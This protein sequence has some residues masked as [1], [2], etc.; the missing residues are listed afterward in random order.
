M[1][2]VY[3]IEGR[4]SIRNHVMMDERIGTMILSS[5]RTVFCQG[6]DSTIAAETEMTTDNSGPH[7]REMSTSGATMKETAPN[8]VFSLF[9]GSRGP[10]TDLPIT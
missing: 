3:D 7:I 4:R 8:T 2:M 1:K 6:T 9:H 10:V 5:V